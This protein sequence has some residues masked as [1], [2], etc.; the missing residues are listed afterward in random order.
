[1]IETILPAYL[2][3]QYSST[4][5]TTSQNPAQS[6]VAGYGVAGQAIAGEPYL[7]E[8]TSDIQA[9][10]TAYNTTAQS[11]LDSLNTLN[12]PNY[13]QLSAPLLDWV[14]T[15][16]YG[17][18]R[19]SLGAGTPTNNLFVYNTTPYNTSEYSQT[20]STTSSTN[21]VVTDD[22]YKR[23]IT[24][25][26]YKGDGFEYTTAWLKRRVYRFLYG[27]NGVSPK[28]DQT[29]NV[30]VTYTSGSAI[31]ITIP[32]IQISPILK[33]AIQCGVLFLPFQ[34]TYTVSY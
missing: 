26:F 30:S 33:S 5:Q 27:A 4:S 25:N 12:L 13:T 10:F 23:I 22:Y 24:W 2:Y 29:Y 19:P 21:Y 15:S 20:A 34:Y 7:V 18:E 1:M 6:G 28:I 9:F 8:T 11:Y 16:L 31:T 17:I 3:Q 32:N 14:G